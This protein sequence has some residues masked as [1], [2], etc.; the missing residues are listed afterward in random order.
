MAKKYERR[1]GS[2]KPRQTH[3]LVGLALTTLAHTPAGV[4]PGTGLPDKLREILQQDLRGG[5]GQL[6]DEEV[7][8]RQ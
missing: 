3:S 5:M 1:V 6:I 8:A 7:A 2:D 4:K